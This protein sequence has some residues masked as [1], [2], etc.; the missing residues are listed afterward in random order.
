MRAAD[1]EG[2]KEGRK[3]DARQKSNYP[4]TEGGEKRKLNK[5]RKNKVFFVILAGFLRSYRF[6]DLS[7]LFLA[8]FCS[9]YTYH[10]LCMTLGADFMMRYSNVHMLFMSFFWFLIFGFSHFC[11]PQAVQWL[12]LVVVLDS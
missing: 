8:F 1:A 9:R 3:E 10:Q 4:N 2:R 6:L 12:V 7:K 5:C 11:W